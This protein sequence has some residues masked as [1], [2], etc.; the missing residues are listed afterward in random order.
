MK[1]E[2]LQTTWKTLVVFRDIALE[3]NDI[4]RAFK[5]SEV[6]EDFAYMIQAAGAELPSLDEVK[7]MRNNG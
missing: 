6:I 2:Q 3:D 1:V 4:E 5:Y 7:E